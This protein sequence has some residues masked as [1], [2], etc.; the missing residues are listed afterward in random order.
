MLKSKKTEAGIEAIGLRLLN[1]YVYVYEFD[2][3]G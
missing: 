2:Y 1:H 3:K